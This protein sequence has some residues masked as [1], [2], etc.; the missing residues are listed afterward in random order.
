MRE[1]CEALTWHVSIP[2]ALRLSGPAQ[3][4]FFRTVAVLAEPSR[5]RQR[6]LVMVRR[7]TVC[8]SSG[9]VPPS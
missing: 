6:R 5:L 1:R 8:S 3:I 2:P 9:W 7:L 4:M